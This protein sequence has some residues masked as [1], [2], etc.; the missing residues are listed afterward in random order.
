MTI[1]TSY[2]LRVVGLGKDRSIISSVFANEHWSIGKICEK[3]E[4]KNLAAYNFAD[5]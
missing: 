1:P 3:N 2:I 4:G 5:F